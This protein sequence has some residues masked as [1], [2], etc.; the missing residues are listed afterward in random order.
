[1]LIGARALRALVQCTE[2]LQASQALVQ[3]VRRLPQDRLPEWPMA[4]RL[5]PPRE[6]CYRCALICAKPQSDKGKSCG[7]AQ[8]SREV[9][10]S[11]IERRSTS[12]KATLPAQGLH[13]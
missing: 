6:A 4:A 9:E 5:V 2:L 11:A 1:M 12:Q 3:V 7:G 10:A 8:C 13:A